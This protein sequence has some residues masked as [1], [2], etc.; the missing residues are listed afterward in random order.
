MN[1]FSVSSL[2]P[3]SHSK[4]TLLGISSQILGESFWIAFDGD[5]TAG[6][7]SYSIS[8]SSHASLAWLT[9]S[10]TTTAINSP[11]NLIFSFANIGQAGSCIGGVPGLVGASQPQGSDASI[12]APV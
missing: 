1:A 9:V 2:F 3:N 11:T 5:T 8:I 12:S 10:A 6:K 4:Q 7:S